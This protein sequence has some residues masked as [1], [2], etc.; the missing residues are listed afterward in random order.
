[1]KILAQ[2]RIYGA[3][4]SRGLML[5]SWLFISPQGLVYTVTDVKALHEWMTQHFS[6]HPLFA[7]VTQ[8]ELV[9]ALLL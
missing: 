6:E 5:G 1:M 8:Q 2:C 4:G 7:P 9:G 3:L